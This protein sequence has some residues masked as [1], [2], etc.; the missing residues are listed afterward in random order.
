MTTGRQFSP[1]ARLR[2]LMDAGCVMAPGAFNGLAGRVIAQIGF[3]A[4]YV[5]GAA[6]SVCAGVPDVGILTLDHFS[7]IVREVA[8]GSGLPVLADADT[9]F[10]EEEMVRRTVVEYAR[11]GAAGLHIEDQ[12]F[13]KR[14][15]HLD[16]KT[17]MTPEQACS[18]IQWAA[19]AA[20]EYGDGSFIVCA[21]TDARGVDGF[22]AAVDR[23]K[24][25]VDAGASMIFPEGLATEE[26][27]LKFVQALRPGDNGPYMLANMTEFGKTPI[28]PHEQFAAMGYSIVIYPVTTLRLAM[29]AVMRGL[30][31][32]KDTG[33][34][35][36]VLDQM[37]TRKELY[38]AI[39][40][41]PGEP[42]E[43]P[44]GQ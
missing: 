6:T 17:L 31:S 28:I 14:C 12:V 40:Y 20:R 39:G 3:D 43:F 33:S 19:K 8:D 16:G 7:R 34:V 30:K 11:A 18:R 41:T 23:A 13:P 1:G 21:R 24:R 25:Y 2:S 35:A 32:L 38:E 5:S 44:I 26:E 15:G 37:Q 9:G 10:G 27:F 36:D 29:G 4:C 22:D 42:W